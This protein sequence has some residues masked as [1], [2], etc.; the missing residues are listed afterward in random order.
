MS[1]Q[2]QSQDMS[3][4]AGRI[5]NFGKFNVTSQVF[6]KTSHSFAL[7]NLKPLLPGHILVCPLAVKPHL[8]DLTK[9]EVADLFLTVTRVQRTL[10]RV[11]RAEAFNVAVQDG[12]A[13]GQSVPHVHCHVIPRVTGDPGGGDKVH[14]WLE[15]EEG[16]VGRH[17]QEQQQQQQERQ[18]GQWAKDEERK[19][20]SKEEMEK[21]ARWLSEEMEKDGKESVL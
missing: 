1:A 3:S 16:N 2:D 9:D 11:Y 17:Q 10:K 12:E 18:A 19:P 15:G 20:R 13:A 14:E 4:L 8:S 7:V 21:E 6:H 5:I